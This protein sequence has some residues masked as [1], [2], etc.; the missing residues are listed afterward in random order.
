MVKE[1]GANDTGD[2]SIREK[3]DERRS[4]SL[5]GLRFM[6]EINLL[7]LTFLVGF[8]VGPGRLPLV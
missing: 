4:E 5:L 2:S 8:S 3:A 7:G 6:G 1:T